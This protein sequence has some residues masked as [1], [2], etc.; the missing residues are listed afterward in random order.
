M[1]QLKLPD[2]R[3]AQVRIRPMVEPSPVKESF[4]LKNRLG[5]KVFLKLENMNLSGSFKIR[6]ACNA[7]QKLSSAELA[8]GIVAASA[9]NHAQAIAWASRM[10]GAHATI[11]MPDR[12]P[13]VKA[14]G[15]RELGAQVILGGNTYDDAFEAATAFVSSH[16]GRLIHA[17]SNLDVIAGQGTIG[18]ELINQIPDIKCA[19]V[20]IGGGGM[21]AGIAC[22][23]KE[24]N[25]EIR[26]IGA[27]SEAF[28]AVAESFRTK[29]LVSCYHGRTIADGIAVKSPTPLTFGLVMKYV[30]EIITVDE[31][32]IAS[33]LMDLME[34]DHTLAEGCGA[35]AV[36]ALYKLRQSLAST[37]GTG[38][39]ACIISGGNIDVNLLS[40]I[41][42][43]G[44]RHSGRY[45]R[46]LCTISDR[47]G[48]LA[49]LLNLLGKTGANLVNVQHDRLLGSLGFD[50]V[51]VLLDLETID[52]AHQEIIEKAI[53]KEQ[54]KFKVL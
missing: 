44:M 8:H 12:T 40:R 31:E 9:G 21:I 5:F 13:L 28:P 24:L 35:V 4:F 11:F 49:D 20:P 18:L 25:P 6:G 14:Q 29:K 53:Q 37:I 47:P 46:I 48:R 39:V 54:L 41:I 45:M 26:I 42:P 7:I 23:L 52:F 15:T 38:S 2:I 34:R 22:A 30:D 33:S 51:E 1:T 27:Q 32:S 43:N 16:G 3:E 19:I 17:F 36:A 10:V 50:D